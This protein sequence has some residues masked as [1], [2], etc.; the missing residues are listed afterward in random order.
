ME[1]QRAFLCP[2]CSTSVAGDSLVVLGAGRFFHSQCFAVTVETI[3]AVQNFV[4]RQYPSTFCAYCLTRMFQFTHDDVR[5]LITAMRLGGQLVI[6]LTLRYSGCRSRLTTQAARSVARKTSPTCGSPS[7]RSGKRTGPAD[8]GCPMTW[9]RRTARGACLS[10]A[11]EKRDMRSA[12]DAC[13]KRPALRQ[14][15]VP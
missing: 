9:P 4:R 7:Q 5:K 15:L 8:N 2:R 10:D 12:H 13:C 6:R 14:E 1:P 3:E 11:D